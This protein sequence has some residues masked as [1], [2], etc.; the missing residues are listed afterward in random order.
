MSRITVFA[1]MLFFIP[2]L[3]GSRALGQ[4]VT[5]DVKSLKGIDGVQVVIDLTDTGTV[6]E[7]DKQVI[8][9]DVEPKLQAA[10]MH[11][12]S[13]GR[14]QGSQKSIPLSECQFGRYGRCR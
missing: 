3:I 9:T 14:N 11:V 1:A 6:S 5:L 8:R 12:L 10:G 4:A 13:E 7:L 2:M